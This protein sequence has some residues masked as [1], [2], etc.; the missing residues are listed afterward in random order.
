MRM[1]GFLVGG[2]VGA[3]AAIYFSRN[4]RPMLLSAVNWD[5]ALDKAGQFVRTAKNVWDSGSTIQTNNISN[6]KS[7]ADLDQVKNMV[8]KEPQLQ[9]QVN[10][11][12]KDN[13]RQP[14]HT[15]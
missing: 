5:Q 4:N 14:I 12:L 8:S 1:S 15:Q 13:E 11:I 9:H 7:D 2:L 6:T 3:A 10:E